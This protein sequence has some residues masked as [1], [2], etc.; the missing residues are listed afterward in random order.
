MLREKADGTHDHRQLRP[1]VFLGAAVIACAAAA[2]VP[3]RIVSLSPDLTEIIYGL[4]AL[5]RVVGVSNFETYPPAVSKILRLGTLDTPSLEKISALRPD[6]VIINTAQAQFLEGTLKSLNLKVLRC[7]NRTIA[8][9]YEAITAIGHAIGAEK[10]A[11]AL[12]ASTRAGI[13][14]VAHRISAK[15][16][17]NR[18]SV[19]MIV[20]RLP[21]TLQSLYMATGGTYLAELI[22]IAGGRMAMPPVP[23]GYAKLRHEDLLAANPEIILDFVQG[24]ASRFS[25]NAIEPWS[26]MPE[27]KAVRTHH[28]FEVNQDF[29]P[30]AS[31]RIVLTAELFAKLIHP[32]IP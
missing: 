21:G 25:G 9:V 26:E 1:L 16:G 22:E 18:P 11:A 32:E 5:D 15:P 8:E 24:P 2:D 3:Q 30:H 14:R 23:T 28:V 19:A 27:L 4:G 31:Q 12:V 6:L 7:S 10:E 20:D 29:V 17:I 13:D